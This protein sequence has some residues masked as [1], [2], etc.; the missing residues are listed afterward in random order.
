MA[1]ARKQKLVKP[2]RLPHTGYEVAVRRVSDEDARMLQRAYTDS[3]SSVGKSATKGKQA[4]WTKVLAA[5]RRLEVDVGRPWDLT[6]VVMVTNRFL[7]W[8]SLE[9]A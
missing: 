8:P 7:N 5:A 3:S 6:L 9:D 2:K 1:R 4:G